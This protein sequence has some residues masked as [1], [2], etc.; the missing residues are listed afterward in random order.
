MKNAPYYLLI[1]TNDY[2]GNFEREL[3]AYSTGI[4]DELQEKFANSYK[5]AFWNKIAASDIDSIEE[6]RKFKTSPENIILQELDET[7]KMAIKILDDPDKADEIAKILD[8]SKSQILSDELEQDN[9][10]RLYDTYLCYTYQTVDDWEQDTFYNIESFY[11][12]EKYKCDTIF[13]QLNK[14]LP[15]YL[16]KIVIERIKS[17]FS[18]DVYNTIEDYEWLCQF[19][20]KMPQSFRHSY[21]LIDLEL[22]DS[23]YHLIKKYV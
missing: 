8:D 23:N 22:V 1:H 5:K 19:G 20:E 16:E 18:Q 13:I 3:V 17:F 15:E 12:N 6:Y 10:E 21:E 11:K 2:T 4:L 7:L 9:I 14:P